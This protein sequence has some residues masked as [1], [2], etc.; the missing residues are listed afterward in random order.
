MN[1]RERF[2]LG[3]LAL[4]LLLIVSLSRAVYAAVGAGGA[5]SFTLPPPALTHNAFESN[6]EIALIPEQLGLMLPSAVSLDSDGTP[7]TY[8]LAS[9]R[10]GG[11]LPAGALVDLHILHFDPVGMP[12]SPVRLSGSVTFDRPII[13][14]IYTLGLLNATDALGAPGT[15]YPTAS[16]YRQF[17]FGR[18]GGV[19]DLASI[20]SDR[21]TLLVDWGGTTYYDQLRVFTSVPEPTALAILS[22]LAIAAAIR[23]TRRRAPSKK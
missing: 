22:P 16:Q 7:K 1:P 19:S 8:A 10:T 4:L 13:G 14:L 2:L 20:S 11:I 23:H 17:E 21:L 15:T 9:D 5:V 18:G 3:R 12:S 6:I